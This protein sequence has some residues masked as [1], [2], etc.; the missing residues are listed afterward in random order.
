MKQ[1]A[2][3][4]FVIAASGA[5]V[6]DQAGKEPANDMLGEALPANAAEAPSVQ[7]TEPASAAAS[8][9]LRTLPAPSPQFR[10]RFPVARETTAGIAAP[11]ERSNDPVKQTVVPVAPQPLPM[12]PAQPVTPAVT[13]TA[14]SAPSFAVTPV[15]IPVAQPRPAYPEAPA[16][17]VRVGMKLAARAMP[18]ASTPAPRPMPTTASS[19]FRPSYKAGSLQR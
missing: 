16:R 4:L 1:I 14:S 8:P 6:W 19:R 2:L 13:D 12:P 17:V 15:Y 7:P 10:T 5:Y 9:V 18:M 11:A 3:S